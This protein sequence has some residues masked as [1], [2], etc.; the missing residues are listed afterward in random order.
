MKSWCACMAG[1]LCVLGLA[2][3]A[4]PPAKGSPDRLQELITQLGDAKFQ[5]REQASTELSRLGRAALKALRQAAV[6]H[7]DP[8]IRKRAKSLVE[9]IQAKDRPR[10][11]LLTTLSRFQASKPPPTDRQIA[12]AMHL[13][14]LSRPATEAEIDAVETHL[15]AAKD[16]ASEAEDLMWTLLNGQ[17]FNGRL[18]ELNLKVVDLKQKIAGMNLAER[19]ASVNGAEIQKTLT[20]M[21]RLQ[22]AALDKMS[23]T[24]AVDTLFLVFVARFPTATETTNALAHIKKLKDREKALE[25]LLW[26]L[27]NTREFLMG[28]R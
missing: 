11:A 1:T 9:A 28:T 21:T 4:E 27:L 8:E 16:K 20:E 3:A 10:E 18:A 6:N 12:V 25:D 19:L 5:V 17:E 24:Q 22:K 15:K 23:D 14:S 26:A 7:T 2:N 13:L